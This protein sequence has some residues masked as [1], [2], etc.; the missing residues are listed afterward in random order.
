ML[1][2]RLH[3]PVC[4]AAL[5][6]SHTLLLTR[7]L[8]ARSPLPAG[9]DL[10]NLLN[11]AAILTGRRN[12]EGISQR[13]IDDSIDRIVAGA[14]CCC[15]CAMLD[16]QRHPAWLLLAA[17]GSSRLSR[18]CCWG[19][20]LPAPIRSAAHQACT[21]PAPF[22]AGMEGTPMTDGR[23]KMLVAYHEVR[24]VPAGQREAAARLPRHTPPCPATCSARTLPHAPLCS[25]CARPH[26]WS[27]L[28]LLN[29]QVGHAVCATMT[30]G[31]DPVQKARRRCCSCCGLFSV[32]NLTADGWLG[33]QSVC[34]T[35]SHCGFPPAPLTLALHSVTAVQVT[36]IPRGQAK[37]LTWFIPGAPGGAELG[38]LGGLEWAS[39]GGVKIGA[40]TDKR[41]RNGGKDSFACSCLLLPSLGPHPL[42]HP[43]P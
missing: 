26:L 10:S 43:C 11:E 20:I 22:P 2:G 8:S 19:M 31:H 38:C 12:K 1:R 39:S 37:G 42:T 7:A 5:H 28:P 24:A 32:H 18:I 16:G 36:L 29:L 34:R 35:A 25:W 40:G 9:A 33:L 13:E 17:A 27:T 6:S 15:V 21:P 23:S 41:S 14:P 3:L 4:Q 30:P